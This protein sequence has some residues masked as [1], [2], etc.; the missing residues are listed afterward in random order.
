M[1]TKK[2]TTKI[3]KSRKNN[4]FNQVY[5][6][7]LPLK[8]LVNMN[9]G[10]RKDAIK[11]VWSYINKHSLKGKSTDNIMYNGK[12][13]KGGQVILCKSKLMKDFSNNKNKIAM[14]EIASLIS[15]NLIL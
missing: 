3:T 9:K 1:K 10:A 12:Q 4:S 6:Y 2:N 8:N 7:K 14:T 5:K 13:Y 15:K 11:K